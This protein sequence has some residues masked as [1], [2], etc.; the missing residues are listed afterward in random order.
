MKALMKKV[1]PLIVLTALSLSVGLWLPEQALAATS[2]CLTRKDGFT[3]LVSCS[4]YTQK[5]QES[6]HDSTDQSKCYEIVKN[7]S[8][9]IQSIEE[10]NC[11]EG[12]FAAENIAERTVRVTNEDE[13][14]AAIKEPGRVECNDPASC[15]NNNPLIHLITVGINILGAVV[16]VVVVIVIIIA[17]IQYASAGGNPNATSAAKKRILNAII[18]LVAYL[19]LFVI[20][21]WLLPGGL[22]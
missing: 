13:L 8:E 9:E 16:G 22:F 7:T 5:I 15:V 2:K 11:A 12:Q 20:L 6:G 17:G 14:Q 4:S 10:R 3:S 1:T 21:N 19:F 18:A